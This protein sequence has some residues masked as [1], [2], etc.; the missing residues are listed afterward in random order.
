MRLY[1]LISRIDSYCSPLAQE[2]NYSIVLCRKTLK[3]M[4]IEVKKSAEFRH[5]SIQFI[6]SMS[7]GSERERERQNRDS[8]HYKLQAGRRGKNNKRRACIKEL[9]MNAVRLHNFFLSFSVSFSLIACTL[10]G[11][12]KKK[13]RSEVSKSQRDEMAM[14]EAAF[15][16]DVNFNGFLEFE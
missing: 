12:A 3:I 11:I 8:F 13:L 16:Y 10:D 1:D 14:A 9:L 7:I 4:K 5:S 2:S 15:L 6:S